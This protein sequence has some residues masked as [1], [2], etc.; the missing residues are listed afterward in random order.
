MGGKMKIIAG[1]VTYNRKKMLIEALEALLKQTVKIQNII[2]V[3]N[4]S[5][6]G[7]EEMIKKHY[8]DNNKIIYHKLEN[9]TGG[10]GGFS[11]VVELSSQK[12][13]DWLWLMDDDV[14]PEP[15][16]LELLLEEG[17]NTNYKII[18]PNRK[19]TQTN[20]YIHYPTK[21]NFTNI[22][23]RESMD[24]IVFNEESNSTEIVAVPFE[25][26]LIHNEVIKT[27]GLPDESFFI[28][29]D[30]TD[31]SMR[32]YQAGYKILLVPKAIL[33]RQVLQK[34]KAKMEFSFTWR[35]YFYYRNLIYF[36]KKN[37]YPKKYLR[38]NYEFLKLNFKA[39]RSKKIKT[40]DYK[41]FRKAF[42]DAKN[43]VRGKE[44][45]F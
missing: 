20:E 44:I 10:A 42:S 30:D 43:G 39:I 2:I 9:N 12:E 29:F 27:V 36:Y 4:N 11:K 14:I 13:F 6:D 32:A 19:Y 28:F 18:Q 38:I 24:F 17:K 31:F 7:T 8:L 35:D 1:I 37:N 34:K 26:P 25:G 15:N 22:R 21:W 5:T 33:W 41:L 45:D 23:K 16:C 3:D 40:D